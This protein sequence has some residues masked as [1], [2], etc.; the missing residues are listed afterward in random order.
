MERKIYSEQYR[1]LHVF[2]RNIFRKSNIF[3]WFFKKPINT[4]ETDPLTGIYNQFGINSYL[5]ELSPTTSLK[6]AIVL[7]NIDNY[8]EIQNYHGIKTAELVLQKTAELLSKNIRQT[9]LVGKYGE[10]EFI[11]IL[12]NIDLDHANDVAQRCLDLIQKMS[13]QLDSQ[14]IEIN[15]SCGVS[16]S[17]KNLMSD[18]VLQYADRALFLAKSSGLNQVLDQRAVFA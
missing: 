10:N 3:Q 13:I 8:I 12:S 17:E 6:Y 2:F 16:V 11:M 5:K 7:L 4:L 18:N 14:R 1:K 15:A 9:D